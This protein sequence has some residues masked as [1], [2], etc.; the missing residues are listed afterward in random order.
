[1]NR[2]P[3]WRRVSGRK[4]L[5]WSLLVFIAL[6]LLLPKAL[7]VGFYRG[8]WVVL[9]VPDLVA[10]FAQDA[11][12][13]AGTVLVLSRG[14][15]GAGVRR[16]V[17]RAAA[18]SAVLAT[19]LLDMRVRQVWLRPTDLSLI[20]YGLENRGDLASGLPLFFNLDVGCGM[21]LRRVLVVAMGL[22]LAAWALLL[23]F[24]R[25]AATPAA[26]AGRS[27]R[28]W[29]FTTS[30]LVVLALATAV[31]ALGHRYRY[32]LQDNLL[33]SSMLSWARTSPREGASSARAGEFDE[34]LRPASDVLSAPRRILGDV[35]PFKNLVLV[36][37]ESVRWRDAVLDGQSPSAPNLLRLRREGLGFHCYVPVPHSSKGYFA[38]LAGRYPY[39]G[40]EMREAARLTQEGLPRTLRDELGLRTFVFA[41]LHLPFERTGGMLASMGVDHLYQVEDLGRT[42]GV[43]V[44]AASSFGSD[45]ARLYQLGARRLSQV[46]GPFLAIFLPG[47]AHYP[48]E[49]PGKPAGAGATHDSY[50]RSLAYSD[51]LVGELV[52]TFEEARLVDE[53]LFVLLGDH[54]ES[55]G[56]HGVMVHNSSLY[57]EE[58]TVP[59]VFWSRDGRLS[60]PV[61]RVGLQIDV[62]PTILD[63]FGVTRS[64]PMLQGQSLLRVE[65]P[66]RVY[67]STFY[68]DLML[69]IVDYPT[70]YLYEV[71]TGRVVKFDLVADPEERSSLEVSGKARSEVVEA[72]ERFKAH[73]LRAFP[74]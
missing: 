16:G 57:E 54:G 56:E 46:G 72:L 71:A 63:L 64:G 31:V 73:Q 69:G 42:Y 6:T 51:R 10:V 13:A 15:P 3:R 53:T 26:P 12:L 35:R 62:A 40:I 21:T 7:L 29:G 38:V 27:R 8:M 47:A 17:I 20:R 44:A 49:Y 36:F 66:E 60:D 67:L 5:R 39:P 59:L 25:K 70:K 4:V 58:V 23:L 24:D 18:T 45:D 65:R 32:R 22:H 33:V 48:Y 41:S 1:M 37:L 52:K 50:L 19:L 55:F 2:Y 28:R 30:A 61:T 68:E 11:L 14:V 34:R 74:E 43:P 9:T